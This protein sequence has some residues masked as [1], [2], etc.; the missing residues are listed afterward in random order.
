MINGSETADQIRLWSPGYPVKDV[1]VETSLYTQERGK[2]AY[3]AGSRDDRP[4]RLEKAR[5]PIA[6]MCCHALAR[7]VVGSNKTPTVARDGLSRTSAPGSV[8]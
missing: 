3:R 7:I 8:R 6:S 1:N 5:E 2:Q 4:P